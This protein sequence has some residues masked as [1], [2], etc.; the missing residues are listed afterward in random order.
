MQIDTFE[1]FVPV[2]NGESLLHECLESLARQNDKNFNITVI[3]NA[4]TD[5]TPAIALKFAERHGNFRYIRFENGVSLADNFNRCIETADA[6]Y[7]AIVH[8]DDRVK[9]D[10]VKRFKKSISEFP[11]AWLIFCQ[12]DLIDDTG[13][14][15]TSTKHKVRKFIYNKRGPTISGN[16]GM[17]R[18]CSYNHLMAPCAIYNK[19]LLPNDLKFKSK[20][21][22]LVDQVFW[23]ETL[24]AGG[25]ISQTKEVLYD[26][27]IHAN[28]LSATLRKAS[29]T[30][31]EI[32]MFAPELRNSP[33]ASAA[34]RR[35]GRLLN[36][37]NKLFSLFP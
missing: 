20:Y 14:F 2:R 29:S 19:N 23:I 10:Y 6:K 34:W 15:I 28:Q 33:K 17:T 4:S 31:A 8:A 12:G 37:R 16:L 26:H 32:E 13:K 24:L 1:V 36:L 27:R 35:Y 22:Y 9:P 25:T 30:L 5:K 18:L 11:T 21:K 7:F 3:D